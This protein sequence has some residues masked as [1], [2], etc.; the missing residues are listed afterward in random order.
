M[1]RSFDMELLRKFIQEYSNGDKE[2]KTET[3]NKY[4][5]LT[6][7]KREAAIKRFS[8]YR[9]GAKTNIGN[10][11]NKGRKK[12]YDSFCKDLIH[13]IW[14]LAG[15]ICAERLYEEID[16]YIEQLDMNN[17]LKSYNYETVGKVK[18]ISLGSL[19]NIIFDFPRT[20]S[21][22]HKGN[23]NIYKEVKIMADFGKYAKFM[24]GY[25]EVDYV[26]HNGGLSSGS[27]AI[28][29]VYVDLYS[30]FIARGCCM[31]KSLHSVREIDRIAHN[32][33]YFPV[34]HYHPDNDKSIL[35]LLLN[36]L[37]TDKKAS[38]DLSR[39]RPYKKNDN[40][41]VEQKNGD[42]VRKLIG[43]FRHD[44]DEEV[45]LLNKIYEKADMIENFFIPSFK[46]KEKIIDNKGKVLKKIYEKP[47]T[48]YQRLMESNKLKSEIKLELRMIY[49]SL[50][51]VKLRD[52]LNTLLNK[53]IKRVE[54]KN[55]EVSRT[56][57]II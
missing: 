21:R 3:L 34:L 50:N 26:E 12:K 1:I 8:R 37:K 36:R 44:S 13:T 46:L 41:H 57:V 42:K 53:L 45:K 54:E 28:T 4:V 52:E 33:I 30:Q 18:N 5:K 29:G 24:P 14:K 17:R 15:K 20:S 49:N 22:K 19:K 9:F 35:S 55:K 40:A 56:K 47:K 10:I 48:P 32:K 6:G 39:S 51:L 2:L 16:V 27:F 23:L 43:Y 31:G 11:K 25:V 38:Y 7:I